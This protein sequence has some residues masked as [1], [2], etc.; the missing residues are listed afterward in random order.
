M[1]S[2]SSGRRDYHKNDDHNQVETEVK[3][4]PVDS[5]NAGIPSK[6]WEHAGK[7]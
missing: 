2:C 7:V 6:T 4:S 5:D 3:D 1:Y